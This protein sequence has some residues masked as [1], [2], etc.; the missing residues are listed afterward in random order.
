MKRSICSL[1]LIL[2]LLAQ[3]WIPAAA[4]SMTTSPDGKAFIEEHQGN[5]DYSLSAAEKQVNAFMEKHDLSLQQHQFD[6]LV[7]LVCAYPYHDILDSGYRVERVIASGDYTDAELASALTSWVKGN[8][9][10][11]S[12]TN[13]RRRIREAKL[14]LYG[15]YDGNCNAGFRYV[16][17]NPNG[18]DL[19]EDFNTV[20]CF[21]YGEAYGDL[22]IPTKTGKHFAGW[23][24][25]S[26]GGDHIYNSSVVDQNRTLH[27]HWSDTPVP[28]PNTWVG[29]GNFDYPELKVSESL[30]A[31]VKEHEGFSPKYYWDYSQYTIGYG[32]RWDPDLYPDGV[33]TEEEADFELR[34]EL[35]KFEE[36]V[37]RH[38][39]KGTVN[40]TQQQYD[41]IISF[42]FNLGGQWM[43]ASNRIYQYVL[44]G[45]PSEMEFVDAMGSWASAGGSVVHGLMQRRMDEADMY[46]NG[47]YQRCSKT[48][49]GLHLIVNTDDKTATIDKSGKSYAMF[50]AKVGEPLGAM[51]KATREGHTFMGWY[52]A[53]NKAYN[54]A[55]VAANAT[56]VLNVCTL[57]AK[58]EKGE[59]PTEPD[60]TVPTDPDPS[61][62]DP[63]D[64]TE[65][66]TTVP[67][68]PNPTDPTEPEPTEPRFDDVPENA[69]Y[70]PYVTVAVEKGL[71]NGLGK[72]RFGPEK[73]MTRAMVVTVLHR[74]AGTPETTVDHPFTDVG[75]EQWY[76]Q[77]VAWAYE[78]A[79]SQGISETRFGVED[80]ITRQQLVTLLFRFAQEVGVNTDARADL[81]DF[82]DT[83]VVSSYARDA[84]QW[85]VAMDI[86]HGTDGCLLPQNSATR[87]Q[88]AKIMALFSDLIPE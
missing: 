59:V 51:P 44:Y 35:A 62:P 46:L 32:T 48:Y 86:I 17:F 57:K 2:C 69:W 66:G 18:G 71:L 52:D 25:M 37:D 55:T 83:P 10:S 75:E 49:L 54:A 60:P 5:T 61:E 20:T 79:I 11:V 58:W 34:K 33:I 73:T 63:T 67:T 42:T 31:F 23:F 15:S 87:A 76:S 22:G 16:L 85:A 8:D 19:D 12:E 88:C 53:N 68:E 47:N 80:S 4:A 82:A 64:P 6:A 41:A 74:M 40:H 29:S 1:L 21:T 27:A 65:P 7:D 38:L 24:T 9:G 56:T 39:K 78:K 3:L 43:K 70:A 72:G 36:E 13:L 81:S 50:Y 77:A 28:N 30:I 14:F 84:F 26:T 45:Y